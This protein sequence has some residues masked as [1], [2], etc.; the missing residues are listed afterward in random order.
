MRD[1]RD[2]TS[3]IQRNDP[4][5]LASLCLELWGRVAYLE[6]VPKKAQKRVT[7]ASAHPPADTWLTPAK[8]AWESVMGAG[9]FQCG[10]AAKYLAPLRAAYT[11]EEIGARIGYY[12]RSLKR[13]G[14]TKYASYRRFAET[15]AE[16]DPHALACED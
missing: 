7:K 6:S 2:I 5:E 15:V 13:S 14:E 12:V 4:A 9:S 1:F 8:T 3:A 10:H 16:W 11:D